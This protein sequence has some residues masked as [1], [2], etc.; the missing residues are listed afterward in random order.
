MLLT[1]LTL[2][3]NIDKIQTNSTDKQHEIRLHNV[4]IQGFVH[5]NQLEPS[6]N[7]HL[8]L[9]R[10]YL[11]KKSSFCFQQ[12]LNR[13]LI[14]TLSR[15]SHKDQSQV[16]KYAHLFDRFG[17]DKYGILRVRV[18]FCQNKGDKLGRHRW[19]PQKEQRKNGIE[20]EGANSESGITR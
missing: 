1:D 3:T 7:A 15:S 17:S 18:T 19:A 13:V 20:N 2:I 5:R 4:R 12:I 9:F 10:G 14:Y 6:S 16:S 11:S 8:T